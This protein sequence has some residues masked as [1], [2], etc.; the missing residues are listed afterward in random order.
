MLMAAL[1]PHKLPSL[2]CQRRSAFIHNPRNGAQGRVELDP[3]LQPLHLHPN[4]VFAAALKSDKNLQAAV[5]GQAKGYTSVGA[6]GVER[7]LVPRAACGSG[8]YNR[9]TLKPRN[10]NN[11][12]QHCPT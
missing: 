6:R 3:G 5:D 2:T 1:S 12:G 8:C 7:Q 4:R 10:M 11:N 9:P